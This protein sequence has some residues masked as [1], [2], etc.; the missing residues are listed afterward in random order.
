MTTPTVTPRPK[1]RGVHITLECGHDKVLPSY[2]P[3]LSAALI[4]SIV[5]HA[6][7]QGIRCRPC[8]KAVRQ[9]TQVHGSV[10]WNR[11]Q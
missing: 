7:E 3:T 1:R 5:T 6:E 2:R 4:A 10:A 9:H 11:A 8:G